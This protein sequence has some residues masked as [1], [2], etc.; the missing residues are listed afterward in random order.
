MLYACVDI[1]GITYPSDFIPEIHCDTT[2]TGSV[3]AVPTIAFDGI[4]FFHRQGRFA[5]SHSNLSAVTRVPPFS[6]AVV[7]LPCWTTVML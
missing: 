1:P 7:L 3:N 6:L 2:R 4:D 5:R